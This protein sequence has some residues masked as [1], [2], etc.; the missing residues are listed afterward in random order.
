MSRPQW[1]EPAL[2]HPDRAAQFVP[3]AALSG[4][5]DLVR[6]QERIP[7]E[8]HEC[9]PEEVMAISRTL[10]QLRTRDLVRVTY[11]REDESRYQTVEGGVACVEP[12]ARVLQVVRTRIPFED[13]LRIR[14]LPG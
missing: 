14:R 7:E 6:K 11:Y 1:G 8:R 13:I 12:D 3:F 2:R 5:Y 4:Y 9:S 10:A